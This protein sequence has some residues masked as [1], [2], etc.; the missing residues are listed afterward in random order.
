MELPL[1]KAIIIFGPTAVGKSEI[2]SQISKKRKISLIS[3]DS[4]QVYRDLDIA[5]AKPSTEERFLYPHYL[6]DTLS[7][8]DNFNIA[9]FIEEADRAF[10]DSLE[11][12]R[13]PIISG[14]A[15]FYI[16]GFIYG[17]SSIPACLPEIRAEVNSIYNDKGLDYLYN[18]LKEIDPVSYARINSNDSF[19]ITR[20]VEVYLQ[21]KR[22]LSS[23]EIPTKPR[24]K[25]KFYIFALYRSKESIQLRIKKRI[26]QMFEMGLVEEIRKL[27]KM[28]LSLKNQSVNSIGYR[29]FFLYDTN[30]LDKIKEA[31]YMNTVHYAKRQMTFFRSL[32]KMGLNIRWIGLD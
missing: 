9:N 10:D 16:K 6:I 12:G 21:T 31:I 26:E 27:K 30:D 22:P 8:F 23:F 13:I 32:E 11:K 25:Y 29:E 7:P 24:E 18:F 17:L 15:A 20:A 4:V 14:S 28:G 2:I 1:K 5:S 19:R 3:A